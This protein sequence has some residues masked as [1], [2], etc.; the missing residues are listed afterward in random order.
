MNQSELPTK[1]CTVC[2]RP[3]RIGKLFH[4]DTRHLKYVS[5]VHAW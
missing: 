5:D 4:S 2:G 3:F 1:I